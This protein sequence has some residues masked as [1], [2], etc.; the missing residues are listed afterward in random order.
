MELS[1]FER[2]TWRINAVVIL[3]CGLLAFAVLLIVGYRLLQDIFRTR[4]ASSIVN[5]NPE[6]Q[7]SESL[8]LS[9]FT[10]IP[11]TEL[12]AA[13]LAASQEYRQSYYS[14]SGSSTRNYLF[15]DAKTKATNWLLNANGSLIVNDEQLY[16]DPTIESSKRM[17]SAILYEVVKRDSNRDSRLS[18]ADQLTI[19]LFPIAS[20]HVVELLTISGEVFGIQQLSSNE[21]LI[22]Y[23][24]GFDHFAATLDIA[25]AK[26]VAQNPLPAF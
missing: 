1:R 25:A 24:N 4:V 19:M 8:R 9:A 16:A 7:E 14:K 23:R 13:Q 15:L 17:T 21:V 22:F 12:L 10:R 11:G 3:V 18:G 26:I 20:K 6:T 2:I 5:V